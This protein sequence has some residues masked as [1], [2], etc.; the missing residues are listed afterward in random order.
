MNARESVYPRPRGGTAPVSHARASG[1]GL[2]PPTRGNLAIVI[3]PGYGGGSIPAHAGE[4]T[5]PTTRG[6]APPVYPRPR[7]GTRRSL[8]TSAGSRGLSPPTR[9]NLSVFVIVKSPVGSIPAHAGEPSLY[10]R[11]R[12]RGG[13]YPRPRGG[14]T[15]TPHLGLD[16]AGLS[17][18]TRGN[19]RVQHRADGLRRSIPA[20]AGEPAAV[21][22]FQ[23]QAEVYPR[24][25]GGTA[26][27]AV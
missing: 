14:T 24:P 23:P 13:V 22:G 20:H 10:L 2:S 4:P 6:S 9:G 3:P 8:R 15:A 5:T 17:P 21:L 1:R 11:G 16:G 12:P 26:R 19:Q 27:I 7:G 18:P 25:R